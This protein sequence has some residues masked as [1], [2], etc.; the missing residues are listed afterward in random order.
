MISARRCAII[1]IMYTVADRRTV[2]EEAVRRMVAYFHPEE[3]YLFGSSARGEDRPS[4]DLDFL[5]V[6]SEDAPKEHVF[7]GVYG[8]LSGLGIAIDVVLIRP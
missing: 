3:I 8:E 6:L 1:E 4:S 7:G 5:V 2:I